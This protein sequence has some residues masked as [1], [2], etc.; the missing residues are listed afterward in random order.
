MWIGG[1][2]IGDMG[3]HAVAEPRSRVE[4]TLGFRVYLFR[5]SGSMRT[6]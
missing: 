5:S 4:A 6:Y 3:E 2:G 1:C